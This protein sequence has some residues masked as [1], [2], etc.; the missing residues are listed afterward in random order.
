HSKDGSLL[1]VPEFP[2]EETFDSAALCD[3]IHTRLRSNTV[4][5][6]PTSGEEMIEIR[7]GANEKPPSSA[8]VVTWTETETSPFYCV[9]PWMGPPNSPQHKMGLHLVE[10]GKSQS[11]LVEVL[12]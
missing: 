6:G 3:R 2:Q 10:P 5:F 12:L 11:F 9:E 1:P 7:I 4:P 8:T